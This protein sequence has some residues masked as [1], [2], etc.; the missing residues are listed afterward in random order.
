MD[1]KAL[2]Q[3]V[4]IINSRQGLHPCRSD[5]W[6]HQTVKALDSLKNLQPLIVSSIG[7]STWDFLTVSASNLNFAM[8]LHLHLPTNLNKHETKNNII[9]EYN[10]NPDKLYFVFYE[11]ISKKEFQTKRDHAI[12][13][14]V[15]KIFPISIRKDGNLEKLILHNKN[16]IDSS[17]QITHKKPTTTLAYNLDNVLF[18]EQIKLISN[19]YII[20]WTKTPRN[21]WHFETLYSYYNA[22]LQSD[23]YPRTAFYALQNIITEKSIIASKTHMPKNIPTVSF[24]SLS[25]LEMIPL[26][27]WRSRYQEMSFEP[28][29]IGI[30]KNSPKANEIMEVI[31]YDKN[32][33]DLIFSDENKIWRSQSKGVYT[34]WETEHELRYLGDFNLEDIPTSDLILFTRYKKEADQLEQSTG[35]QTISFQK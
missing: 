7:M 27:K 32:E 35:I 1:K 9:T 25:P 16:K 28:Y 33:A 17:F 23:N 14:S 11:N 26:F 4:S 24:T 21:K 8:E 29:G 18:T 5:A 22:I 31:Y 6:V 3:K 15:D 30:D 19:D 12:I 13:K 2:H 20:H 10:L 34:H